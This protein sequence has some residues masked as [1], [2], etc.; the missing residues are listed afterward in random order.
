MY[1][2]VCQSV[3][4]VLNMRNRLMLVRIVGLLLIRESKQSIG[5]LRFD[6]PVF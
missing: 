2:H 1:K 5:K 4:V 3:E 6:E